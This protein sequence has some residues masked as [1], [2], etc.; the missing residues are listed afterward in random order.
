M[1]IKI[2]PY[3]F[4]LLIKNS[5]YL[6]S[7][8]FIFILIV[9]IIKVSFD[10]ISKIDSNI[11]TLSTDIKSLQEKAQLFQN[12]LPSTQKLDEDIK[13]LNILI[14]NVED[15][16]SIIYSLEEL[17]N[18]TGFIID[19]YSVNMSASTTEKLRLSITGT[20]DTTSFMKFLD[21]YNFGGGRLITSDRIE[22]KQELSGTIKIDLTFYNTNVPVSGGENL[23][24]S[25]K[26]FEDL[27][28]I[29]KKVT[30]DFGKFDLERLD[31]NYPKKNNPFIKNLT[32][33]PTTT[34]SP[35]GTIQ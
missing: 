12:V 20:G 5:P 15:F 34:A 25:N 27:E 1:K 14:P 31:L 16:F 22:L 4:R 9:I 8:I 10:K 28:S 2:K 7:F 29:K 6:A 26:T 11:K 18:K 17:S 33:S 19:G 23:P 32:V 3:L 35:S 13:L 30:F 21:E 24:I